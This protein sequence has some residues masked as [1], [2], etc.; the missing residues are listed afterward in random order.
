MELKAKG[1]F[2]RDL[3]HYSNREL[4]TEVQNILLQI[5]KAPGISHIPNL[6]KLKKFDAHFRVKV[7]G[8][9]RIG[10]VIRG[11]TVILV[12]FGHRHTFYKSFP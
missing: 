3:S 7:L 2:Y 1:S 4:A 6:K 9:Y 5:I 11:S 8:N 10:M 12:C